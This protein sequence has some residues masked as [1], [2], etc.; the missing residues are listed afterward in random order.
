[1]STLKIIAKELGISYTLVSKVL[2]GKMGTTGASA[3]TKALIINKA[4]ELDYQ[5]NQFAV[6]LKSGRKNVIGVFMHVLGVPGSDLSQ[7]F[8]TSICDV[9]NESGHRIWLRFFNR[10]EEFLIACDSKL[11]RSVD[12]LI[13]GGIMHQGIMS[14]LLEIENNGL[15]I[16]TAFGRKGSHQLKNSVTVDSELQ[17]FLPA[18]H[19]LEKGCRRLVHFNTIPERYKGF[20]RAHEE[21]GIPIDESLV[22]PTDSFYLEDGERSTRTLLKKGG[23]KFDGIVAASDAQACGAYRILSS[24]GIRVPE[25]VKLTGVDNSPLAETC[26]VPITS[27]TA[28]MK[29]CGML[30]ARI[31]LSCLDK[32]P[33]QAETLAPQLVVRASSM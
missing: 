28:E 11:K 8:I 30:A 12:G 29:Q 23:K 1:M 5:P 31:L 24:Q 26:I 27:V 25:D 7:Q 13:V 15:P 4:Q 16:V 18:L 19:L 33:P 22:I 32:Q 10:D 2:S 14:N 20:R 6:A 21:M 17:G 9:F 3:A